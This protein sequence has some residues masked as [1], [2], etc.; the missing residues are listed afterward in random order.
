MSGNNYFKAIGTVIS[1]PQFEYSY[2][3]EDFFFFYMKTKRLSGVFDIFKVCLK[4]KLTEFIEKDSKLEIYGEIR[5]RNEHTENGNKLHVFVFAK[6]VYIP[7]VEERDENY[8]SIE[9]FV[10]KPPI[11]RDTPLGKR[12][13]DVCLAVNRPHGKSSYIPCIF[14]GN[15][16]DMVG[17][18]T[19]GSEIKLRGRFQSREY[20]KEGHIHTA[21]EVSAWKIG[22]EKLYE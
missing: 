21:Y 9:G 19:V 16:A 5:T 3:E 7:A 8:A 14:W 10:A 6:E 1:E 17:E 15:S 13:C 4:R 2:G 22:K 12:I 18:L 11:V 20:E